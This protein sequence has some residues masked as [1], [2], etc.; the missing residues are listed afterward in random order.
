MP[1]IH[2]DKELLSQ[3]IQTVKLMKIA[4]TSLML[5][6]CVSSYAQIKQDISPA[7]QQSQ[8]RKAETIVVQDVSELVNSPNS[9]G[10]RELNFGLVDFSEGA[11]YIVNGKP[12]TDPESVKYMLS[13]EKRHLKDIS[14]SKSDEA[15][16]RTIMIRYERP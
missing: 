6:L 8:I 4:I 10:N 2:Q 1:L 5:F 15:G 7:D 16:K 11:T 3:T 14:I 12:L 9:N 13:D